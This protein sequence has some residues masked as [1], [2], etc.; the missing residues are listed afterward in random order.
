MA[1]TRILVTL[2]PSTYTDAQIR[3]LVE[4]GAD[5]VRIN[6][7]HG[8]D[9]QHRSLLAAVERVSNEVNRH[10]T[11]VADLQGPKHRLGT[12][13]PDLRAL[14][15][16][17]KL[18][19]VEGP[20][21]SASP[22]V[23][24]NVPGILRALRPGSTVLVGDAAV[25]LRILSVEASRA[26][27]RAP[28]G[29]TIASHHGIYFPGTPLP[30]TSLAP[31]DLHDLEVMVREGIDWIALSFVTTAQDLRQ[32]GDRIHDL[33]PDQPPRLLAKIERAEALRHQ[34][35]II[36]A[37]DGIMVA[38]G[39]LGIEL[40]LQDLPV[41]QKELI[42][43]ARRAAKPCV[44]ATQM[45][46]SMVHASRPT[47]AEVSDAANAVLDGA[48]CLMLSEETAIGEYPVEAVRYLREIAE[49]TEP[50]L[51]TGTE[52]P[53]LLGREGDLAGAELQGEEGAVAEA[54][55]R[56][57]ARIGA[58]AIVVPTH[59]GQTARLVARL[60]PKPPLL[61]LTSQP[62]T[63]GLTGLLWGARTRSVPARLA[64]DTLR[65][66]ARTA[67]IEE[68][69]LA[70]G[71]KVV[72]TAGYPVEGRPTNLLNVLEV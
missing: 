4:A 24:V 64:L 6:C 12:L 60:R 5:A 14:A 41:I 43:A 25:E 47:R 2:G 38:R 46:L 16:G 61:V 3:A 13:E 10:V 70:R 22:E 39:D 62:S 31:K 29:G 59:S 71:D 68:L 66:R 17:E 48:D 42:F 36:E 45:L 32:A 56:L 15:P 52:T 23:A 57:A 27:A 63:F 44:V 72:L 8:D 21:P 49:A 7:S 58:R 19:L 53:L 69:H 55:V 35:P 20:G 26:I 33:H 1:R 40:P 50:S 28:R 51:W 34:V 11:T 18:E 67:V 65:E 9:E 30:E 54:A 37:A